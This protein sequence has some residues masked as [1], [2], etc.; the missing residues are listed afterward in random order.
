MFKGNRQ[1]RM[2]KI[3]TERQKQKRRQTVTYCTL[4]ASAFILIAMAVCFLNFAVNSHPYLYIALTIICFVISG[5]CFFG[6]ALIE[7][8]WNEEEKKEQRKRIEI[9]VRQMNEKIEKEKFEKLSRLREEIKD[10]KIKDSK[11][12]KK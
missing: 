3:R 10:D 11:G 2:K 9:C 7:E 5:V 6:C 8:Y 12:S 1:K 4:G